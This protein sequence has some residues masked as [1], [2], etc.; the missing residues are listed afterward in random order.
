M[1]KADKR[2][3]ERIDDNLDAEIIMGGKSY[4]CIIMN[5]SEQGLYMVTAT[6]GSMAEIA[7]S[8][9]IELKCSLPSDKKIKLKCEVK[10]FQSRT[11]PHGI[12]SSMGMAILDPPKE[13]KNFLTAR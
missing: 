2:R 4:H 6:A 9:L 10:W 7:P 3:A 1:K 11:S 5:F 12:S 8:T 13:Y